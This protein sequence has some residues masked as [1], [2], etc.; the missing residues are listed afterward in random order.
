MRSRL[1]LGIRL[2]RKV[3][4]MGDHDD[5]IKREGNGHSR[6]LN[7]SKSLLEDDRRVRNES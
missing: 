1:T 7:T 4:V 2:T 6:S 3:G 5:K